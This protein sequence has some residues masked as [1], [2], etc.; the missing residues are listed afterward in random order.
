MHLCVRGHV[1]VCKRSCI[2]VLEVM[3]LCVRGHVFVLGVLNLPLSMI[4]FIG[5]WDCSDSVTFFVLHFI[6]SI[7]YKI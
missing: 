4:F 7:L 1:F 3:Y 2:Y 5:F 6:Y